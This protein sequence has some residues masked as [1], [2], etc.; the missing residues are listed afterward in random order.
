VPNLFV[1]IAAILAVLAFVAYWKTRQRGV[2]LR[3]L[4]DRGRPVTGRVADRNT[5]NSRSSGD[6]VRVKLAY[7]RADTGPQ[8]RWV[9][10]SRA[11]WEA[12]VDGAPVELVYR[13]DRPSIFSTDT[14]VNHVRKAKGLAPID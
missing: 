3:A 10:V 14:L 9:V 2:E 13:P 4:A 5:L 6:Y 7:V 11:E 1:I 12:F 8:E